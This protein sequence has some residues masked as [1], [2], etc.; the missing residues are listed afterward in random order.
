VHHSADAEL[1]RTTHIGPH[2]EGPKDT[3]GSHGGSSIRDASRPRPRREEVRV[4]APP[5]N[6][7]LSNVSQQPEEFEVAE[8]EDGW[9]SDQSSPEDVQAT[10]QSHTE[11]RL[12]TGGSSRKQRADDHRPSIQ[13][14][15]HPH[16]SL[17]AQIDTP[18]STGSST[19][20]AT[21]PSAPSMSAAPESPLPRSPSFPSD[22]VDDE[23]RGRAPPA[24][25]SS[26]FA[27]RRKPRHM[28]IVSLRGG[29]AGPG[30]REVSPARSIRWADTLQSPGPSAQGSRAPSPSP[31][32]GAES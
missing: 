24:S 7:A 30:S 19:S 10:V 9:V 31:A 2:E 12:F 22:I 11:K 28:R 8:D 25:A 5:S 17:P 32:D 16:V 23:P 14:H 21:V 15:R 20:T 27:A 1:G 6:E 26:T 18:V 13:A 29:E 4:Y 3:V